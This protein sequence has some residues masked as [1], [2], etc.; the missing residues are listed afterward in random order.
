MAYFSY[1]QIDQQF[2][3]IR[4]DSI[5]LSPIQ[6]NPSNIVDTYALDLTWLLIG[7]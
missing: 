2:N 1:T 5:Q 3:S 6:F 4:L 7:F